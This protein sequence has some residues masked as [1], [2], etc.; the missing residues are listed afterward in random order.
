MEYYAVNYH[1]DPTTVAEQDALRPEHRAYLGSLVQAGTLIA[2]GP[3]VGASSP[4]ALLIFRAES[5]QQVRDLLADDPFQKENHV[6]EW[7]VTEWLPVLGVFAE[8]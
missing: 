2:S 5:E 8:A 6:A 1:Y 7:S 4:Q 3:L